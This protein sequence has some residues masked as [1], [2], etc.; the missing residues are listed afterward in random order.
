V[1]LPFTV[2]V[3]AAPKPTLRSISPASAR[4]GVTVAV[5]LTGTDFAA[6]ASVTVQGNGVRVSRL[7]VVNSNTIKATFSV[8]RNATRSSRSVT[9]TTPAGASNTGTF[10]VY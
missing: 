8:S 9:V 10:T 1:A 3:Q 7:T 6:P 2:T 4:R 5:T